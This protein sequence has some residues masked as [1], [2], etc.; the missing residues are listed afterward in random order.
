MI[1]NWFWLG[2]YV[3]IAAVLLQ[4]LQR[5]KAWWLV[6]RTKSPVCQYYF[7]PFG[8]REEAKSLQ[9]GY[10]DDLQSEGAEVLSIKIQRGCQPAELTIDGDTT[11]DKLSGSL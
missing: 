8:S 10:L 7:G 1:A 6:I 2:F 5:Q 9:A 3:V 4:M 11:R